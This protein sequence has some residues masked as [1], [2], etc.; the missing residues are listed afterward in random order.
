MCFPGSQETVLAPKAQSMGLSLPT[1]AHLQCGCPHLSLACW[2]SQ[3]L[4]RMEQGSLS[5]YPIKNAALR[6]CC[7]PNT[8]SPLCTLSYVR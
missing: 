3:P 4:Q 7:L 2:M 6:A 8:W 1:H 5:G